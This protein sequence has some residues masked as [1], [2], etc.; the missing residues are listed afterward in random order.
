MKRILALIIAVLMLATVFAGC[1]AKEETGEQAEGRVLFN[2]DLSKYFD[3]GEY[4]N[5]PVDTTSDTFK[6]FYD[7]VIKSDVEN[8]KIATKVTEGKVKKG[9]T[10]NIDYVGKKD[11]V[12]FEGGTAQGY[13]LEIGSGSFIDGF[14]DG[15]I[16]V[17]IGDTV[18]LNLTFPKD[19]QSADLAGAK[20][21]F[22]VKVNYVKGD[23][24]P[25]PKDF[26][27]DLGYK[28]LEEYE[29]TV[30][31]R[32]VK[33]YL[34]DA[35]KAN[36]KIKN[37][38]KTERNKLYKDYKTNAENSIQSNYG[39]SFK[40]YLTQVGQTEEEFKNDAI[41]NQV[42][43]MMDEMMMLYAIVDAEKIE[44][45]DETINK[46][47][48]EMASQYDDKTITADYIKEYYTSNYGDYYVEYMTAYE[49]A[50]DILYKNAD[51]K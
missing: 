5:I 39:M 19:Y 28:S 17:E 24:A 41:K 35:V 15:L 42:E 36:S 18:D 49:N 2:L 11:G 27:K 16:G 46:Q 43:P 47:L 45:N 23:K 25:E 32:A 14:E 12:A 44:L 13:D 8:N 9:D 22:T 34:L 20:V 10:A 7:D 48:E 33:Q 21:V 26:Y 29:K 37:Y 50:V 31:E 1:G 30:T 51:I 38:P 3:L 4:K 40:D 6:G